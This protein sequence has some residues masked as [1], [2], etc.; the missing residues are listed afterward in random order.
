MVFRVDL[1]ESD[2]S[3]VPE[4]EEGEAALHC[5]TWKYSAT[6]KVLR[7]TLLTKCN[8]QKFHHLKM[9]ATIRIFISKVNEF[10]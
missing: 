3:L 9:L 1:P 10:E 5:S 4:A 2:Y 7:L 6:P 8:T